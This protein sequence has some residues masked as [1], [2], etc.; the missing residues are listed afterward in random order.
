MLKIS[1]ERGPAPLLFDE[2]LK[3]DLNGPLKRNWSH[4]IEH[5]FRK[6]EM[7]EILGKLCE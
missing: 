2:G 6:N 4:E 1:T 7:L 3:C 5:D